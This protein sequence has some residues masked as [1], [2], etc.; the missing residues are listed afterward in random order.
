MEEIIASISRIITDEKT[1][2]EPARPVP[3]EKSEILELTEV[4]DEDGSVRR[5]VPEAGS[6]ESQPP[7]SATGADPAAA[8]A[9]ARSGPGAL[10]PEAEVEP[11]LELGRERIL[12]SATSGAAAAAFAQLG[13]LPRERRREGEL[14][15]GGAD[16][17]LEDI[18]RD[19][20]RPLLQTWLDENLP[21]LVERLVREE[22][23]RVVGEAGLR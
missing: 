20:L 22:I 8:N 19:M 15:L 21:R 9:T 4:V 12:S 14:P 18:V 16:R 17:T 6:S 1:S 11:R 5:V 13:A 10:P 23:A 7:G 3:G 2:V